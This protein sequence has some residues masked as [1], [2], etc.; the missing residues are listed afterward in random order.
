MRQIHY[1]KKLYYNA[2][3]LLEN[4][5]IDSREFTRSQRERFR[6]RFLNKHYSI[7]VRKDGRKQLI[8]DGKIVIPSHMIYGTLKTLYAHAESRREGVESFFDQI[9]QR[10]EGITREDVRKFLNAQPTHQVYAPER[11]KLF[12]RTILRYP[13]QQINIDFIDLS[14]FSHVNLGYKY[15]L[16]MIDGFSK[17]AWVFPTKSRDGEEYREVLKYFFEDLGIR[18]RSLKGDREFKS[19]VMRDLAKKYDFRMVWTSPYQPNANA[20][21]E[22]FNK[23]LKNM[24]YQWFREHDTKI[25][26]DPLQS[27]VYNYNHTKHSSTKQRPAQMMRDLDFKSIRDAYL[28]QRKKRI[29]SQ[30]EIQLYKVGDKVRIDLSIYPHKRKEI[31]LRGRRSYIQ[32]FSD[33]VYRIKKVFKPRLVGRVPE[34]Q[35]EGLNYHIKHNHL[36]PVPNVD[37]RKY[38]HKPVYHSSFYDREKR[39]KGIN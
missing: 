30:K 36:L 32:R 6:K 38:S 18:P 8:C 24:I 28:L 29:A 3:S 39:K 23:T 11:P 31:M 10:Y 7:R 5:V 2:I 13:L 12:H 15:C 14:N 25:W 22:R 26:I 17:Y 16:T 1:D 27:I 4:G 20:L 34:Y 9:R 21:N 19:D 33:Q 37:T 35:L